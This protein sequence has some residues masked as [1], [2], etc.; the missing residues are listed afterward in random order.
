MVG[1]QCTVLS[2]RAGFHCRWLLRLSRN[3]RPKMPQIFHPNSTWT[4]SVF[5]IP[6]RL[7][8]NLARSFCRTPSPTYICCIVPPCGFNMASVTGHQSQDNNQRFFADYP[9]AG[10]LQHYPPLSL[11][12]FVTLPPQQIVTKTACSGRGRRS[13]ASSPA[14]TSVK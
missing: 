5:P 4:L 8:F 3:Q 11:G 14:T 1:E 10:Y 13:P 12:C 9:Q 7:I 2:A 6:L